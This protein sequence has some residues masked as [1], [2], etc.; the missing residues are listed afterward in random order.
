ME[1]GI[2]SLA[3]GAV[4]AVG[5][6][7]AEGIEGSDFN[8]KRIG[9]E[10]AL[11]AVPLSKVFTAGRPIQ[12]A[13]RS[14]ALAGVGE[15]GRELAE[16][17]DLQ[18]GRIATTTGLGAL[19]GGILGH[20]PGEKAKAPV[21]EAPP[22]L[23]VETTAVPGGR[24]FSGGKISYNRTGGTRLSGAKVAD[25]IPPGRVQGVAKTWGNPVPTAELEDTGQFT[26]PMDTT[27]WQQDQTV[28]YGAGAYPTGSALKSQQR[29]LKD[30]LKGTPR[31]GRGPAEAAEPYVPAERT[32][33]GFELG[34]PT[35]VK[36]P[37]EIA[38]YPERFGFTH[39]W[40]ETG[41]TLTGS[42]KPPVA[43]E[44]EM[45][46]EVPP[47]AKAAKAAPPAAEAAAAPV[48][49]D[50][51][52]L[53]DLLTRGK[54]QAARAEG[55][56][57]GETVDAAAGELQALE[58]RLA[59]LEKSKHPDVPATAANIKTRIATLRQAQAEG[60]TTSKPIPATPPPDD[61]RAALRAALGIEAAAPVKGAG[62]AKAVAAKALGELGK[63]KKAAAPKVTALGKALGVPPAAADAP[64]TLD[65]AIEIL[66]TKMDQALAR[67]TATEIMGEHLGQ[68]K[69]GTPFN[70]PRLVGA[71]AEPTTIMEKLQAALDAHNTDAVDADNLRTMEASAEEEV[72]NPPAAAPRMG[73]SGQTDVPTDTR[74]GQAGRV[75]RKL[76][77]RVKAGE[78]IPGS[79]IVA[80]R[81]ASVA[82][83]A[84]RRKAQPP[85]PVP[86]APQSSGDWVKEE[87]DY[88][89]R[90]A[91]GAEELPVSATSDAE[92][93]RAKGYRDDQIAAFSPEQAAY[94]LR[95][96]TPELPPEPQAPVEPP[97]PKGTKLNKTKRGGKTAGFTSPA[98]LARLG[99]AGVGALAGGVAGGQVGHPFLGMA[100]GAA[101]GALT[102][103]LM[104]RAFEAV[105]VPP[106]AIAEGL[107][108]AITPTA[109]GATVGTAEPGRLREGALRI[110]KELPQI[111]RFNYLA[112]TTGLP[113]NIWVGPY[114]SMVMGAIEHI[115]KG[116]PRGAVLLSKMSPMRFAQ[117]FKTSQAEATALLQ[118][119][120]AGRGESSIMDATTP[121]GKLLQG[122][123]SQM[124]RGDL[125][126]RRLAMEAGFTEDEARV[127]GL[128]S[129]PAEPLWKAVTDIG[130]SSP[131]MQLLFP[132][133]RT[134]ANIGEQGIT[135]VPGLGILA[136]ALRDNPYSG[137]EMVAQQLLGTGTA[138]GAGVIGSQL[139]PEQARL[140]KSYVTNFA[141]QHSLPANIGFAIGQALEQGKQPGPAAVTALAGRGLPLP[142]TEPV[143]EWGKAA[144]DTASGQVPTIPRG[145]YPGALRDL[146]QLLFGTR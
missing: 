18:G 83:Q 54:W 46:A 17:Q 27:A 8:A 80:A 23:Q 78:E 85:P 97:S 44:A 99:L 74:V 32:G 71:E 81:E 35:S 1:P 129:E 50:A 31:A 26:L 89:K 108:T 72:G 138:V 122:P 4:A 134:P 126:A 87:Q 59:K 70:G 5:E 143:Q 106:Q 55:A 69:K 91:S 20:F 104:S 136:N 13:I 139:S 57:A 67:T 56:A 101:A 68:G 102:P 105:G 45:A 6:M 48:D 63:G 22:P 124:V 84:G 33:T 76:L 15:A 88:L 47:P 118:A 145:A 95:G 96:T 92:A 62:G 16:G 114:G 107:Q 29:E 127:M 61:E 125:A 28:P 37:V 142:T 42:G 130:K 11:G 103:A 120:E 90:L 7:A 53:K 43:P 93:L 131:G 77:D 112:S 94:I 58:A 2:G 51:P 60:L 64:P 66:K 38:N 98:D 24:T 140:G 82:E 86:E 133:R 132:F 128:T 12:S 79:E 41:P 52:T 115:L 73:M 65:E 119:G 21:G 34:S 116:D 39:T 30:L 10:A 49:P 100:A 40:G 9:T 111:Q 146:Y 137:K 25:V 123:G 144:W 121:L 141:G 14:G 110:F 135:R 19:L 3:G 117:E 113:A 109:E 36:S 75:Y